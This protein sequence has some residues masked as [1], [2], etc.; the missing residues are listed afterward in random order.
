MIYAFRKEAAHEMVHLAA[1]MSD[2]LLV[3]D[4]YAQASFN[5]AVLRLNGFSP[6]EVFNVKIPGHVV[7]AIKIDDKWWVL[8]STF[9]DD[10]RANRLESVLFT[11]YNHSDRIWGIENDRYHV[12]FGDSADFFNLSNNMNA[13][14][15]SNIMKGMLPAFCDPT[16]G[17][18][19]WDINTFTEKVN[20]CLYMD[21]I[22]LPFTILDVV[23][24]NLS[25]K[26]KSLSQLN[27]DFI[28][29]HKN[30]LTDLPNQ[31]N[32]VLYAYNLINVGFPQAYANAAKLAVWTSWFGDI[33]DTRTPR[34][35]IRRTI[36]WV[37]CLIKTDH[38]L[39]VDQIAFSDFSYL[40][41]KGSTID[42]TTVAYGTLRNMKKTH[43]FWQ[44]EE[45]FIIITKEN[46]GYLAVNV[47]GVWKY[48]TFEKGGGISSISP[49][50]V[51]MVFNEHQYMHTWE[52]SQ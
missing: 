35:D 21:N 36:N 29:N 41:H 11:F 14:L 48:L 4:C 2:M 43:D 20:P 18:V 34:G 16:L 17:E 10:V 51:Q 13:T 37:N 33:L 8:D 47:T 45:L 9:A 31:Y 49:D 3:G 52:N 50:N 24:D 42:K 19:D 39:A 40:I 26:A 25:L 46:E 38:V 12:Y 15:L 23:G 6:E 44:P 7:N 30:P 1:K 5:T 32:Q 28:V 22:S 27:Y